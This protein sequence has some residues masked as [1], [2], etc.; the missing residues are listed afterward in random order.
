MIYNISV[1]KVHLVKKFTFLGRIKWHGLDYPKNRTTSLSSF[2]NSIQQLPL[3]TPQML[4]L[5]KCILEVISMFVHVRIWQVLLETIL[6][7]DSQVKSWTDTSLH[8]YQYLARSPHFFWNW[9]SVG[10]WGG[11]EVQSRSKIVIKKV[12]LNGALLLIKIPQFQ[13]EKKYLPHR[14]HC[15]HLMR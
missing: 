13:V 1:Q 15:P 9:E 14:S 5:E 10:L 8:Q 3:H 6:Y 12:L 2:C 7:L 11:K 4:N